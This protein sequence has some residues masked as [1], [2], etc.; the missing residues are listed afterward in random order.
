MNTATRHAVRLSAAPLSCHYAADEKAL[1]AATAKACY[2]PYSYATPLHAATP[3][4]IN[5]AGHCM[6]AASSAAVCARARSSSSRR[7]GRRHYCQ[8]CNSQYAGCWRQRY[9]IAAACYDC[10]A[11]LPPLRHYYGHE[12]A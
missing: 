11:T 10:A 1:V 7:Y 8:D 9:V 6:T 4:A 3:A 2:A 5:I 12:Y